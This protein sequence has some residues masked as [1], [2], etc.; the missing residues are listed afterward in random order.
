MSAGVAVVAETL[1]YVAIKRCGCFA[2][3]ISGREERRKDAAKAVAGWIRKGLEIRRMTSSEVR[4]L[5][6]ECDALH[7]K[8]PPDAE[9]HG[10]WRSMIVEVARG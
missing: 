6:W 8:S 2:G 5:P 9:Q 7:H 10:R 4:M 3:V 1:F